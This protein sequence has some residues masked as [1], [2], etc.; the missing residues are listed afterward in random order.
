M[1]YFV[2]SDRLVKIGYSA[3]PKRRMSNLGTAS[4]YP[5]H[6]LGIMEGDKDLEM[7]LHMAFSRY[8][9]NREWFLLTDD[10]ADFI[11]DQ[12]GGR[13]PT[14]EPGQRRE[15]YTPSEP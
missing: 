8:R 11:M 12:C 3:D 4:P 2:R 9:V 5:L 10:I 1:I 7:R 6:L 13:V 15:P 14:N